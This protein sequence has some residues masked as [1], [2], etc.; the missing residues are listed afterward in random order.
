MEDVVDL[1]SWFSRHGIIGVHSIL[2]A[3]FNENLAKPAQS[4]EMMKANSNDI[5]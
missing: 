2:L 5:K 4:S 1:K 3:W